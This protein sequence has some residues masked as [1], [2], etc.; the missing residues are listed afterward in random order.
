MVEEREALASSHSG[1]GGTDPT[2]AGS[3]TTS[4]Q[5]S[6]MGSGVPWVSS[7]LAT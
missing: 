6:L 2:A 3:Y 5:C 7:T 1:L 4:F